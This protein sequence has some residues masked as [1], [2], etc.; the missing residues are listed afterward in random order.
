[1]G[2]Y[3]ELNKIKDRVNIQQGDP[4]F[5][6]MLNAFG[7]ASDKE[8]DAKIYEV[9]S[10]SRYVFQLPVLP[11]ADPVDQSIKDAASDRAVAKWFRRQQNWDASKQYT[12]SS[13]LAI[14]AYI[15][16]LGVDKVR[17]GLII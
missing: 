1:M 16:R 5:D 3:Y 6:D 17:Y 15:Q 8:V 9:A 4:G 13:D 12:E 11:L 10:K 7:A 14:Q 2:Q